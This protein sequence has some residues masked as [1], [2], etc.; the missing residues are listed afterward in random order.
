M[1]VRSCAAQ[2]AVANGSAVISDSAVLADGVRFVLHEDNAESA[3]PIEIGANSRIREG[4]ILC[5]GVRIGSDSIIGHNA[6][7]RCGVSIGDSTVLSHLVCV[8]RF[9][10]IGN[11]CR[12]SSLT[13]ITGECLI[14]DEVQ[15]G[16][17]VV[18]INDN[19]IRWRRD[20]TLR[21]AVFR[22]GC[23]VGSGVTILGGIEIG[24]GAMIGAGAVV[25]RNIPPGVLAY[26]VPAYIQG[27]APQLS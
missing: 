25:T 1:L 4:A 10:R 21:G 3:G 18:T 6:V 2:D 14:E 22:K 7:I 17:R 12:I 24:P 9:T 26:G 16:A 20:P 19:D 11:R 27:E 8:E 23:R 15:I 13:H 5:S